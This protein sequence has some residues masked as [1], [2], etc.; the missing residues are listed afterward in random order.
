MSGDVDVSAIPARAGF[1]QLL[2]RGVAGFE[3]HAA[4]N[5]G[6]MLREGQAGAV[7]YS[8]EDGGNAAI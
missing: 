2:L 4:V 5:A 3:L 7:Y 8:E 6:E 1:A